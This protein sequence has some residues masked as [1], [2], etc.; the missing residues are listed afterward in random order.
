[1]LARGLCTSML[2]HSGNLKAS[3]ESGV[4]CWNKASKHEWG[5]AIFFFFLE[6]GEMKLNRCLTTGIGPSRPD[7]LMWCATTTS[8]IPERTNMLT[9]KGIISPDYSSTRLLNLHTVFHLF[10]FTQPPAHQANMVAIMLT[11]SRKRVSWRQ[12]SVFFS[13]LQ[14]DKPLIWGLNNTAK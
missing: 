12:A 5:F 3:C 4:Y 7:P 14:R 13:K 1:M 6:S 11:L 9:Q 10:P 2:K 8:C